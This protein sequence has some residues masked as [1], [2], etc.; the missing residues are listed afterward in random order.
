MGQWH[1]TGCVLCPQNCGLEV[2]QVTVNNSILGKKGEGATAICPVCRE[3]YP[4]KEGSLCLACQGNSP[5]TG[6]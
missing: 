2:D 1:K 5:Y 6:E 3:A 4:I